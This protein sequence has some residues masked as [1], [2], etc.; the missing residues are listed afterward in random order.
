[1]TTRLEVEIERE[2]TQL[3]Q[4]NG[5]VLHVESIEPNRTNQQGN[6]Q[7]LIQ[8]HGADLRFCPEIG[9][10]VWD[11]KRWWPDDTGEVERRAKE[12]VRQIYNEAADC[13]DK[14]RREALGSWAHKS[15]SA[16]Q[17]AAMITLAKTEPGMPIRQAQLDTNPWLL[18]VANG[19]LDLQSGKLRQHQRSDRI[20]KLIDIEY[21][22]TSECPMWDAFL[23]RV[24]DGN[25]ELKSFLQR[26]IGY[27]LTGL[28]REQCFFFLFGSGG[29]GKTVFLDLM[30]HLCG[31]YAKTTRAD[32][33]L[34]KRGE[35][36]NDLARLAGARFV[37]ASETESGR[38]LAEGLV[39]TLTGGDRIPARFLH[40]EYF[41][42]IPQFKLWLSTNHKPRIAGTDNAIWRRIHL[43]PFTVT[44]PE[45][46][47]D[48][49]LSLKLHGE[50]SG[51]LS[52]AVRGCESWQDLGLKAPDAVSKATRDY[53]QESDSLATFVDENCS[54]DGET[55]K[56][57][58]Y[59]AYA[60]WAKKSAEFAVSK[61]EFGI[62]LLEKGFK[63][64]R[65]KNGRY[66][67]GIS[68]SGVT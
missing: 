5:Q 12:T 32:T 30:A 63:D 42:F 43:I 38:R 58:L 17:I 6:A 41:E 14:D 55:S 67:V 64:E 47:R 25:E 52:W 1:V 37:S 10:L 48:K 27:S 11:K 34:V 59:E 29:N 19:T 50:L 44:I 18:N 68:L 26:A 23:T 28:T 21:H 57:A 53:R 36:T 16:P 66:W 49:E 62:R 33:F 7:R 54:L 2:I 60:E 46:E 65:T 8:R 45:E 31:D 35:N 22:P 4:T 51:I 40:R 24:M 13:P 56:T 20:T 39:K 61:R 9:W 15:E 3:G